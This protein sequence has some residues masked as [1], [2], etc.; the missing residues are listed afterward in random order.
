MSGS[1]IHNVSNA[2]LRWSLGI[3]ENRM[4]R[5]VNAGL[6]F[7]VVQKYMPPSSLLSDMARLNRQTD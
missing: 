7:A 3:V 1:Y 4:W 5:D 2:T 6:V